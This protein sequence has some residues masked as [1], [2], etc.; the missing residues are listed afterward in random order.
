MRKATSRPEAEETILAK[1]MMLAGRKGIGHD[2]R[3][4]EKSAEENA[5]ESGEEKAHGC[6]T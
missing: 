1:Q 6:G 4:V 2:E 3:K 5:E